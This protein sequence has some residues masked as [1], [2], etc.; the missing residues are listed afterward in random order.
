MRDEMIVAMVMITW[1]VVCVVCETKWINSIIEKCNK[2]RSKC[3]E[4]Q[5]EIESQLEHLEKEDN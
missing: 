3:Q 5:N 4:I 2:M 1:F